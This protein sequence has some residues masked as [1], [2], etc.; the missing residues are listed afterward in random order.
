MAIP[1]V[2][3][4]PPNHPSNAATT[5]H[6]PL[7]P[8][9]VLIRMVLTL[10]LLACAGFGTEARAQSTGVLQGYVY[11]DGTR[12]AV[13][14]ARVMIEGTDLGAVTDPD[15]YYEVTLEAGTYTAVA[16]SFGYAERSA[17]V[18]VLAGQATEQDFFIPTEA[19]EVEGLT[20]TGLRRGQVRSVQEKRE[21]LSVVDAISADE[22]GKLPDLNVAESAQ[23]VPGITIRTDRGEGRFVSIRG[24]APN[25]NN[26]TFNGQ[27]LASAAGT[28]AT[29]LDLVPAEM[30]SSIEVSKAVLPDQDANALGGSV[31]IETLTAFD[32]EG[33]IF[34]AF[35]YG[36]AH[37]L[38]T[39]WGDDQVPFRGNLLLGDRFGADDAWGA[40][41]SASVSRRAFNTSIDS[42]AEWEEVD[43]IV[44]P[45]E[46][47]REVEDNDRFRYAVNANLDYRPT[48]A[49]QA[50]ARFQFSQFDEQ[51][52]NTEL[53]FGGD[54]EPTSATT[55]RLVGVEGQLD[56]PT[57]EIDEQLAAVTLGLDQEFGA[58]TTLNLYGTYSRGTRERMTFQPEW[59]EDQDFSLSYDVSDELGDIVFDNL[60]AVSNPANFVYT[61]MDI[62]FED[63]VENTYQVG[64][65][66]R[67]DFRS[68][69]NT[70]FVKA[71][72]LFRLRDKD[73]DRNENPWAAGDE[74]LT[75]S[76]FS[77]APPD[78]LQGGGRITVTGDVD[79]FLEFFDQNRNS[80]RF[81]N[82]DPI[83]SAEEEVE[84]DAIVTEDVYAGYLMGNYRMGQLTATGGVRV[85]ATVTTS[86]RYRFVNDDT[87]DNAEISLEEAENDYVN[88]LP[89]LH[90][91]YRI[92]DR[93]Q[94]RGAW[95]NT[96]GR[97][98]YDELAAFQDIEFEELEPGV[99][100]GAIEEGN[101]NLEPLKS[102]NFD[103]SLE[104]YPG[105][106]SILSIGGFHKRIEDPI[107][108]FISTSRDIFGRD[109]PIEVQ[110]IPN[111]DDRF[112]EEV[113]FVQL[114]NADEGT[115][116]GLELSL[117][118][119]FDFLPGRLSGLGLSSNLAVMTSDVTVPGRE[120]EDLPF[121]DQSDLVYNIV[122][123]YQYGPVEL[124]AALNYQS[125]F[126][127]GVGEEAVEDE[128]GD[129]RL[130]VDLTGSYTLLD[131]RLQLN[132]YV[133]NLTNEAE[134]E[135][136]GVSNR[137]IFHAETGRTF[138]FGFTYVP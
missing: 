32:R 37:Q 89:S 128:Y 42:P 110:E 131:G 13:P 28:R 52:T 2:R 123:Y 80:G 112:F 23:R 45:N 41:V 51:F 19:F 6:L 68:G 4:I 129:E 58:N 119:V 102:M 94:L 73:I 10:L 17:E 62:E 121:F 118:Q 16:T 72:G 65:D 67:W 46:F 105:P 126:I 34:S 39:E 15:G 116:S 114:R 120:D 11:E 104:Y 5:R 66:V 115:V 38:T 43:G 81:F 137:L 85:E 12:N 71:G 3:P 86:E 61:E 77:I 8:G 48:Q 84:V 97:P 103:V 27:A 50:Y 106:G 101:P 78:P 117:Q 63:L 24:T 33:S 40:V 18:T 64:A 75:L 76:Q 14:G 100:E 69:G 47:E 87:F 135:F 91:L 95:S 26:V 136:Q 108:T 109:F 83:E 55:G 111:F 21:A 125:E 20:V 56:I 93:V 49:T 134:R 53:Q 122:P 88:V 98:D 113:E 130:T 30:V 54:P 31:N 36:M 60:A 29:A 138:E 1:S 59:G 9:R 57:T 132:G 124:R 25:R 79:Q 96:I 133:R 92:N 90:L 22:I 74:A 82:L 127:D 35:L 70:G 107:Y 99:W 44:A 7:R